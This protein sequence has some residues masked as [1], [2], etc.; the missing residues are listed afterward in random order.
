MR[1]SKK[2]KKRT[3]KRKKTATKKKCILFENV[4]PFVFPFFSSFCDPLCSSVWN[5]MRRE[6]AD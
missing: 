4:I 6:K 5:E 3:S 2:K 1:G